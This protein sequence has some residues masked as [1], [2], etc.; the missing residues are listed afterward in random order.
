M[1]P[2]EPKNDANLSESINN[3]LKQ[4]EELGKYYQKE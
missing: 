3:D 4:I 2:Q 1:Y